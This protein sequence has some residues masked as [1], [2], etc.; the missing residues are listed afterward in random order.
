[1]KSSE[2]TGDFSAVSNSASNQRL[3]S[4]LYAATMLYIATPCFIFLSGFITW[5]TAIIIGACLVSAIFFDLR[6]EFKLTSVVSQ[7][8]IPLFSVLLILCMAALW[9]SIFGSG[10]IGPQTG[11]QLK[12]HMIFKDLYSNSWPVLY[13]SMPRQM[14][15]LSYPLGYYL[16]PA[17][18]SKFVGWSLGTFTLYLW[19][20]LGI[21]LLWC[22]F[23]V[24]F[25]R[26][27]FI[28]ISLFVLFSGLDI[29]GTLTQG[30]PTPLAGEHIEWWAGWTFL[31]YSS[32]ATVM[33]WSTQ[34]GAAQWLL[35]TLL[36]YRVICK[37]DNHGAALAVSL[38]A[39]WSHLTILGILIFL[40]FFVKNRQR[41]IKTFT[42]PSLLS[43]PFLMLVGTYYFSKSVG[44]IDS[45]F[46]WNLWPSDWI[47]PKLMWF[48]I[49]EFGTLSLLVYSARQFRDSDELQLFVTAVVALL[50]VPLYHIG[51]SNDVS[52][53]VSAIPLYILFLMLST[54][55]IQSWQTQNKPAISILLLYIGISSF[56]PMNEMYR[57]LIQIAPQHFFTSNIS[58]ANWDRGISRTEKNC[59]IT[60]RPRTIDLISGDFLTIK[61]NGTFVIT[62][63]W[64]NGNYLNICLERD[65]VIKKRSSPQ[66]LMELRFFR[67]TKELTEHAKIR[68]IQQ[69]D[70]IPSIINL[71]PQQYTGS[72]DSVFYRIFLRH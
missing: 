63:T 57:Q 41:L 55:C 31:Q 17:L 45:G 40:P 3:A 61:N 12:N 51:W 32:N 2:L 54:A 34:H 15:F 30:Q 49:F 72:K 27:A 44:S 64:T 39:F 62:K 66:A 60:H 8:S 46:I 47:I 35:P 19:T 59:L 22:W 28:V 10:F 11:D 67:R 68:F 4:F 37:K 52:M 69:P 70:D 50:L 1:M 56:T 43:L 33:S 7:K 5:P 38:A 58:D 9:T 21:G 13:E 71:W 65:V 14:N 42:D 29:L 36:F 18:L 24:F 23:L 20:S 16:V 48:Y 26:Y 53:R 25:N 6:K